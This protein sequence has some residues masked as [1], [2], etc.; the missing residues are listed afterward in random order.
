MKR[1]QIKDLVQSAVESNG[2]EEKDLSWI[3]SHFSRKEIKLFLYLLEQEIRNKN[4]LV[5]HSGAMTDADKE[6]AKA[7]FPGK[8]VSFKRDDEALGGGIRLEYGD[9]ILDYSVSAMAQR[10]INN[11]R[12][13]I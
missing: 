9:F 8:T 13:N 3:F 1:S 4:A 7:L 10:I 2:I 5:I 12:E 6:R 11:I